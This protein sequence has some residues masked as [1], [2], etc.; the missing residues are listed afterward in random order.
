MN[1][2]I[3]TFNVENLFA[4][5]RFRANSGGNR[6]VIND[7][8]FDLYDDDAKKLTA[9]VIREMD[10]DIICLQ[11]VENMATLERF[12]SRYLARMGYKY[13]ILIDSHDRRNI[14]VAFLS[15]FEPV[16]FKSYRDARS[17]IKNRF[18]FSRD[19]LVVDFQIQGKQLRLYGNHFKSMFG[20][21][22][23][24]RERREEQAVAVARIIDKDWKNLNYECDFVVLGDLNDYN[25][26]ETSLSTLLQHEALVDVCN[27]LCDNERWTHYWSGGNK[28]NQLDYLLLSR[29]LAD[30]SKSKPEITRIGLPYRAERY[31]GERLEDIG[32]NH[33]K[34]SDHAG[35]SIEIE[36]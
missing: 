1:I 2:K 20:G 8:S 13:E 12:N 27:R 36:L 15:R 35:L 22:N 25:D 16:S 34:A 28:Y 4:R 9:K 29:H 7:T 10:C 19:C 3:G 24:T 5:Y 21:R 23:K 6:W 11:E 30:K 18:L 32:R 33:P 17:E 31:K 26:S 14:D